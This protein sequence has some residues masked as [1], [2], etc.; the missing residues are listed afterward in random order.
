MYKDHNSFTFNINTVLI[1]LMLLLISVLPSTDLYGQFF[2]KVT[3]GNN[4]IVTDTGP[5]GYSGA[6]WID[7]DSDGD[8]DLFINNSFLYRNDGGGTFVR[9]ITT[10]GSGQAL[11]TGNGQTWGDFDNDGDIDVFIVGSTSK[12]YSNN[13]D[14]TFSTVTSGDIGNANR[15]WTGTWADYNNDGFLD[16]FITHPAGFVGAAI[17]NHLFL[18][19]TDGRFTKIDTGAAVTQLKAHTVATWSDYDNDGDMDLFIGSGPANG[20]LAADNLFQNMLTETGVAFFKRINTNPIATTLHDGQIWNWIDYDNDGDL[21]AYVTNWF[22]GGQ[23]TGRGN[24][25]F[26][27]DGGSFVRIT[28]GSIVTDVA[29]SLSSVWGDFDNDGDLDV[30]VANDKSQKDK[31]YSNNGDG[32]FTS[33]DNLAVAESRTHRGAS[34]GDYDNDGDLDLIAVGIGSANSLFRNDTQNGNNWINITSIGTVSNK[35]A[36]GAKERIKATISGNIVWQMREISAQ[37]NFNGM[38]SLRS[39]FGLRDATVVDSLIVEWPLG[40]VSQMADL[41]VNQFLTVTE[42]FPAGFLRANS[43]ADTLIGNSSLAV[44]FTDLSLSDPLTPITAWE[45]DFDNDGT[46]DSEDQNPTWTYSGMGDYTVSLTVTN[47]ST[48]KTIVRENYINLQGAVSSKDEELALPEKYNLRQNYPNPFNPLTSIDYSLPLSGMVTLKVYNLRGELITEL[49]NKHQNAGN[50]NV[51][52]DAST[53][54][55]GLYF[56]KLTSGHFTET[57]KMVLLK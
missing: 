24:S 3:D 15:G 13:G 55:S 4:H 2:T 49:V 37:N 36:I 45:W 11:V 32:T 23:N 43:K 20:T 27:N 35:S 30:Y 54:A 57:M 14:N 12:L 31:Y 10:L 33:M 38:N 42:E 56:Y 39:H 48:T 47:S 40:G 18:N 28:T 22:G 21:D 9:L 5:S 41:D 26:R 53:A 6:S 8:L 46:V 7:I 1:L 50:Y 44:N 34:A 29:I 52:W 16:L 51:I 17:P 19:N 25:L